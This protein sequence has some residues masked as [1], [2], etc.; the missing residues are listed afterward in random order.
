MS[1]GLVGEAGRVFKFLPQIISQPFNSENNGILI[2]I[3]KV[4][5]CR[6]LTMTQLGVNKEALETSPRCDYLK[7]PHYQFPKC[8]TQ[9][10]NRNHNLEFE[11]FGFVRTHAFW[12]HT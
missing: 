8:L 10:T 9:K 3:T 5:A 12:L 1:G 6:R 2:K 11:T 7:L 4:M